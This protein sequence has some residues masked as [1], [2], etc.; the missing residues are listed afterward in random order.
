M[1]EY[2]REYTGF[3]DGLSKSETEERF[4]SYLGERGYVLGKDLDIKA[5][6]AGK[7]REPIIGSFE[8]FSQPNPR[9]EIVHVKVDMSNSDGRILSLG[10]E[11]LKNFRD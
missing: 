9:G 8:S 10:L 11:R 7:L 4:R 3:F 1:D 5:D 2:R 6:S